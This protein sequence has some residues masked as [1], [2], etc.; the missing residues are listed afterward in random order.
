MRNTK[1]GMMAAVCALC[2]SITVAAIAGCAPKPAEGP[3]A[4]ESVSEVDVTWS[5]EADCTACHE[6]QAAS[7][8]SIPCSQAIGQQTGGDNRAACAVCHADEAGLAKAHEEAT[9]DGAKKAKLRDTTIN[10]QGCF[11]CHGSYEELAGKTVDCTVLTDAQDTVVN[12]HDLPRG[13]GHAESTC[14]DCHLL[15]TGE[16]VQETAPESCIVCHHANEYQCH[17]CHQ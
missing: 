6:K 1:A 16:P 5:P 7:L 14:A 10:E 11:A 13:E 3:L 12:P 17:T 9:L 15:H 2:L 8:A 4:K